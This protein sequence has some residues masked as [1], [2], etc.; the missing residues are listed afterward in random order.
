MKS[1]SLVQ[2]QLSR[3]KIELFLECP[4]CFYDDL[5]RGIGRPGS[6]PYTLNNAVD[7]L[8]KREFDELRKSGAPHRL[9]REAGLDFIPFAHPDLDKWRTNFTGVRWTDPGTGW[10]LFGAID[11]VWVTPTGSVVVADYKA[12]ARQ[13][14]V[15]AANIYDSYKRQ[16]EVYQFLLEMQGLN[17]EPRAWFYY[18]NGVSAGRNFEGVL[19]FRETLLP[20]DG[21]RDWVPGT[22]REAVTLATAGLRPPAADGCKW[23]C[24]VEER[25]A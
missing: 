12:T 17:V 25:G 22:F 2:K 19:S 16:V 11:D 15:T 1:R 7:T 23:C 9:F 3:S 10:T 21:N 13:T 4:R 18:C 20:Y 24:Y 6:P 8:L 5:V 14:E